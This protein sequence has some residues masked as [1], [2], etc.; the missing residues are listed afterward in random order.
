MKGGTVEQW[1]ELPP[2]NEVTE[3]PLSPQRLLDPAANDYVKPEEDTN[4]KLCQVW[5]QK[6]FCV[7]ATISAPHQKG[8]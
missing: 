7:V 1:V 6:L 4:N 8:V 2:P 5:L 3:L